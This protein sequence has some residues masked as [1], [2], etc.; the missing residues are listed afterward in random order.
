MAL[1][2][3][4]IYDGSFRPYLL[5]SYLHAQR[6][7]EV[8]FI[9]NLD[10]QLFLGA[11]RPG[12]YHSLSDFRGEKHL[13]FLA[14]YVHM[15]LNPISFE[16][17]CFERWFTLLDFLEKQDIQHFSHLDAVVFLMEP[18]ETS[19]TYGIMNPSCWASLVFKSRDLIAEY[20]DFVSY[21][22]ANKSS[23]DYS[24]IC[25][26]WEV[27]Q[28]D[29]GGGVC[30]MILHSMLWGR[31]A[32]SGKAQD[33][34]ILSD[35]MRQGGKHD[36]CVAAIEDTEG[37][38]QNRLGGYRMKE[39][40]KEVLWIKDTPYCVRPNGSLIK[41]G[42]LHLQGSVAKTEKWCDYYSTPTVRDQFKKLVR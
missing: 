31:L 8:Q 37:L 28:V 23:S 33:V 2:H 36:H 19:K 35:P 13:R 9:G 26:A 42:T 24:D 40:F 15:S 7:S 32:K 20:I 14:D 6:Q 4:I 12:S 10:P 17:K 25:R 29:R 38:H 22:Y 34:E 27:F 11:I 3:I 18:M 21:V 5:S 30:D 39:G 16:L 1:P 41:M